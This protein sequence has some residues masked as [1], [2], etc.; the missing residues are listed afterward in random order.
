MLI[1]SAVIL[2]VIYPDCN[3]ELHYAECRNG[4]LH[5]AECR[6]GELHYAECRGAFLKQNI[7]LHLILYIFVQLGFFFFQ[8]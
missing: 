5:Y 4:E 6:N 3:G 1:L 2:N 7:L 8:E